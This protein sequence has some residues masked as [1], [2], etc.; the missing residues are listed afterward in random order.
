[1]VIE[2]I[3]CAFIS[4]IFNEICLTAYWDPIKILY[5]MNLG[6]EVALVFVSCFVLSLFFPE[7]LSSINA[8]CFILAVLIKFFEPHLFS[9]IS[10][11]KQM[12]T[13]PIEIINL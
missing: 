3:L 12:F 6:E 8:R 2:H 1:M 9:Y 13:L 5:S 7:I 11:I 10:P 4:F